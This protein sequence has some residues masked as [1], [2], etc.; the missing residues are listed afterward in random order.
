MKILRVTS[1][2]Y[3]SIIGGIGLHAHELSRQQAIFGHDV[4]VYTTDKIDQNFNRN[5]KIF[6]FKSALSLI[7]NPISWKLFLKLFL[8][9]N[10]FDIIHAH[11]HLF[12]STNMCALIRR[13]G[14]SP[15]V[16][17]NHGLISQTA[18]LWLSK[19]YIPTIGK[20]TFNSA[21]KIICYTN[22]EKNDLQ[23]LGIDHNKIAVIHN[24]IEI[25]T[26][27][28]N[29]NKGSN[30][31]ILWIGRFTAGKG[32]VYLIEAFK[33]LLREQPDLKLLMVGDGPLREK[34]KKDIRDSSLNNSIIMRKFIP[35]SELPK[36]YQESDIFVLPSIDEG[37][38]RTILEAM[39]S[40][41]PIVCTRLPQLINIVNECAILI[42]KRDPKALSDAIFKIISDDSLSQKMGAAGRMYAVKN[43]SWTDSV[44]KII[45]LYFQLV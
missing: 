31:Q 23:H 18:P 28:P 17:T 7:D 38:P 15:L 40:G 29:S 27:V 5:Y 26:F 24:G 30:K 43:Y 16:I 8:T 14:S 9:R 41:L 20:W 42:P 37:V 22:E 6:H 12:L 32:V 19:I 36:I 4:T 39:A 2:M 25:N 10:D 11:S 45:N 35:N 34:I 21:D 1:Q 13:I 3:P 44:K 33:I